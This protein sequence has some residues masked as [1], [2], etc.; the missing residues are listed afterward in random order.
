MWLPVPCQASVAKFALG[1][2]LNPA[3]VGAIR[4]R[5]HKSSNSSPFTAEGAPDRGYVRGHYPYAWDSAALRVI[6]GKA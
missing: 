6:V 2:Q 1:K 3:G 4:V 5:A